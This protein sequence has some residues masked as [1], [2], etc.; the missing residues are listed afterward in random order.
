MEAPAKQRWLVTAWPG[1]GAVAVTAVVYLLSKLRMRRV[2][3]FDARD[4]FELE[5]A[6]VRGGL[7][8]AARLPRSRLFLA[9]DV[10]PG[11]DV[12]AFLGEAQPPTGKF[13][14]CR[15]LLDKAAE[16]GATRVCGFAAWVTGPEP[17]ETPAVHGVATDAKG[18]EELRA[19]GV[20]PMPEG[21]IGGLNGVLLAAASER[22]LPGVGLL[23]EM[24]SLLPELPYPAASAAVLKVFARMAGLTLDLEELERYGKQTREQLS[25]AYQQALRAMRDAGPRP[26]EEAPAAP[27]RRPDELD[28]EDEGKVEELFRAAS[29]DRSKAFALKT[30]LD[31][32]G[33][34][35]RYEDRFLSLF[36]GEGGEPSIS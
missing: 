16:L 29:Q 15:R 2:A 18:L 30:E 10:A 20:A 6:D 28:P 22:G 5:H 3:E 32:L 21:R 8:R 34:F 31:R 14:L 25:G 12:L 7:L 35:R 27:P 17:V 24:P 26:E 11:V 13:A 23:G 36:K 4:L 19:L 33:A 9:Q 1:M